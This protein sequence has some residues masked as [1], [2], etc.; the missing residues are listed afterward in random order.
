MPSRRA[1]LKSSGG[2]AALAGS[3]ALS[4]HDDGQTAAPLPPSIQSL[5]SRRSQAKPITAVERRTRM[6]RARR[7]M[8]QNKMDALILCSGTS[9]VYFTNIDW[10]GGERLFTCVVPVTGEPFFVC[11]AFEEDRA[12]EQIARGPFT[13]DADVRTWHE[14]EN[15]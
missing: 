15:P 14:H 11:P 10:S 1:F 3:S 12:R 6:E 2:L 9:L 13:G 4:R 5:S 8:A 7:L